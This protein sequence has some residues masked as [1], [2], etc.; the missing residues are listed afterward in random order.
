M[1]CRRSGVRIPLAPPSGLHVSVGTIFTFGSDIVSAWLLWSGRGIAGLAGCFAGL[2]RGS[3]L[4]AP[5]LGRVVPVSG[6]P[7]A[8][9][10]RGSSGRAGGEGGAAAASSC[11]GREPGGCAAGVVVLAGVPCGEDPLVAVGE[12]ACGD[13]QQR[14]QAHQAVPAAGKPSPASWPTTSSPTT[15]PGSTTSAA[16]GT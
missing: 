9:W 15:S 6:L 2:I 16:S 7:V 11:S 3:R 5:C 4:C 13:E 1:A 8:G 12:Q 10:L 14:G